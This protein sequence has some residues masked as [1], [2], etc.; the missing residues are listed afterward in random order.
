[1]AKKRRKKSSKCPEPFNTLIDLAAG[2]TMNMIANKMEEKHHYRKRGVPNPYRASAIGLSSGRL[3]STSDLIRLG[4]M[5]GAMGAFDPDDTETTHYDYSPSSSFGSTYDEP[6][7]FDNMNVSVPANNNKYAWRLNCE[8]GSAYGIYP[9][10]YETRQAYNSA[11]AKA[12]EGSFSAEIGGNFESNVQQE[13]VSEVFSEQ[14]YTY[15]KVSIIDTGKNDYYLLGSMELSV[16]DTV[17]VPTDKGN[18]KAI[19]LQIKSFSAD[20]VPKPI[21]KTESIIEKLEC[22]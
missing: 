22:F 19:I 15:C 10:N 7:E 5:M 1:M 20:E 13:N 17:L 4:G 6:W 2:A 14:S 18:L 21:D 11:L 9:H 3:K 12:K 8:D 16:G